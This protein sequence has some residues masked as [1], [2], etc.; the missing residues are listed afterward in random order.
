MLQRSKNIS[1]KKVAAK[2][3]ESLVKEKTPKIEDANI[4]FVKNE[5]ESELGLNVEL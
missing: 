4:T 1:K 3:V 2:K 5:I